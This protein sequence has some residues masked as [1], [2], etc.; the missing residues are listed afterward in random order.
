VHIYNNHLE[1]VNLQLTRAYKPLPTMEINK[2]VKNIFDFK[3]E[4]FQ[5]IGYDPH[6]TIKGQVS[7]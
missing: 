6:P 3:Y 7:I 4:D 5:L 2:E 1:Q